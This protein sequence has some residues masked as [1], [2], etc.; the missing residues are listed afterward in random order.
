[1][2]E[3]FKINEHKFLQRLVKVNLNDKTDVKVGSY[4]SICSIVEESTALI[5]GVFKNYNNGILVE[6]DCNNDLLNVM[7]KFVKLNGTVDVFCSDGVNGKFVTEQFNNTIVLYKEGSR[8]VEESETSLTAKLI[9]ENKKKTNL[10]YSASNDCDLKD[11]RNSNSVVSAGF[12][13]M[14]SKQE[15]FEIFNSL[16]CNS[17]EKINDFMT[18]VFGIAWTV[19][20]NEEDLKKVS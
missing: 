13:E 14:E 11:C 7:N 18:N 17:V 10:N 6:K 19:L 8:S 9:I 1:M 2:K 16:G 3:I 5:K 4:N 20:P 12:Y 15:V